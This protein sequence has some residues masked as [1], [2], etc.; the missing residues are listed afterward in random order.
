MLEQG[1]YGPRVGKQLLIATGRLQLCAG[2]LAFDA[3][4]TTLPE[5][6]TRMP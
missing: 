1:S 4:A 6:V 5:R 3:D 2:W